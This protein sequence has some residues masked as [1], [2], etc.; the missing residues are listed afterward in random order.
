MLRGCED[1]FHERVQEGGSEQDAS[2][3]TVQDRK[4]HLEAQVSESKEEQKC[5]NEGLELAS[6]G[7]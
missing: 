2:D 7:T 3:Q 4:I 6:G 5:P 1:S